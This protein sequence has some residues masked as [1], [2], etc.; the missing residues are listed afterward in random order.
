[1][2]CAPSPRSEARTLPRAGSGACPSSGVVLPEPRQTPAER[3]T[4]VAPTLV[5]GIVATDDVLNGVCTLSEHLTGFWPDVVSPPPPASKFAHQFIGPDRLL[6]S[7]DYR[8]VEPD[9]IATCVRQARLRAADEAKLYSGNAR[10]RSGSFVL[11]RARRTRHKLR[12]PS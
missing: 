4:E 6:F 3:R 5:N 10:A 2:R 9:V 8:W 11:A 7:S 12:R 1:M